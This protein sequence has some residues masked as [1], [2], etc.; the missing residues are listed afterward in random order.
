MVN[1]QHAN[2]FE[3]GG[4][5]QV[6]TEDINEFGVVASAL[7]V[8]SAE[9]E[10]GKREHLGAE[11]GSGLLQLSGGQRNSQGRSRKKKPTTASWRTWQ[12]MEPLE[13]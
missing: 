9:M 11:R 3:A 5:V 8:D 10:R 6:I 2:A 1:E 7:A 12:F 13:G 4:E